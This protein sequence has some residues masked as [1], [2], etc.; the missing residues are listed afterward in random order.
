M[1]S[2]GYGGKPNFTV[3]PCC[4]GKMELP[5]DG[6]EGDELVCLVCEPAKEVSMGD[7]FYQ[8]VNNAWLSDPSIVIPPEYPKWGS[9]IILV[10]ESLKA[11]IKLLK[12][13]NTPANPDEEKLAA[14]WR[15]SMA[16]LE[17]W[18]EGK[19]DC[20]EVLKELTKLNEDLSE[21]DGD[22]DGYLISL[23]KV[24]GRYQE[25]GIDGPVVFGKEANL[26][27]TENIVL[28]LSP[29]GTSLP[30][31]D[32]YFDSKF[33]EQRGWFKEHLGKVA[34]LIGATNLEDD[35]ANRVTRMETKLAQLQMKRDQSRQYDQFFSV[36]T[37]DELC[38]DVNK[39]NYL[40]AKEANYAEYKADDSD[41]DKAVLTTAEYT[42]SA[43][44]IAKTGKFMEQLA[45]S[46]GLRAQMVENYKKNYPDK[47]DAA[48]AQYRMMVFD[49]DYFRRVVGVLFPQKNRRDVKAYLQYKAIKFAQEYC[50]KALND[51]FFDFYSRKLNGQQEQK[52]F[53]KRTTR[54]IN[55]WLGE[56]MG[57]IYVSRHFSEEDKLTVHAMVKE[58]L[59]IMENSLTHND[60]LT[61]ETKYKAKLKLSKFVVKLGYPDKWKNFDILDIKADDSFF[62]MRKKVAQF[63][64]KTEFLD[65]INSVKDKTKWEMNPQDVNAY[66]HPLNNE[67]VFPAAIMQPPF[68]HSKIEQVE[69][70]L[71]E[72]KADP[73]VLKAVNFG[74]IGAVI[75]HEITHGYD[76][77]GRKFDDNG[78]INDWWQ[79]EDAKLF[80]AK[81]DLMGEQ[82]VKWTYEDKGDGGKSEAKVHTM[83]AELT[84]G[85]NLAD[86]GGMSLA[87]QA[88]KKTCGGNKE[89]QMAFFYSWA[90]IWK[91]KESKASIIQALAADPHA[92]PS[93]RGNLVKN[94]DAFYEAFD[95]KE[96]DAMYLPKDKR[97]Q[98]W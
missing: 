90:H 2:G 82:T 69:F 4:Q 43:E 70:D 26:T 47:I 63:D 18:E 33:E 3:C 65:K 58:V 19:G 61:E 34:D 57:K 12:E 62:E 20:S 38:A 83:N 59:G 95:V 29:S 56:L 39:M 67:I 97:V 72:G 86:L 10:D 49:G 13:L 76:D 85:E 53:E 73:D 84:M 7:D 11:Q 78:N 54:T 77:Q 48:E 24:L 44:D 6:N 40:K 45:L 8:F 9:F 91:Q 5:P 81:C 35:F 68:Y 22:G 28:D 71:P 89:Q 55:S 93:F 14:V 27:D 98:M 80:K 60:W 96:G 30:S 74:G 92:P 52:T 37:L 32:Y 41:E 15:A 64:H 25:I 23:A 66:F 36:T 16:R 51:E 79:E 31:R 1:A 75:A 94:V 21:L 88:L 87:N 46:M 50:T 42:A 17:G